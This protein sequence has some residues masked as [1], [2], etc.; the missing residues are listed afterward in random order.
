M[1]LSETHPAVYVLKPGDHQAGVDG[2]SINTAY[3]SHVTFYLMFGS[4]T[5]DAVLTVKSGESAGTKTTSET[6]YYRL[7]GGDQGAAS[8]DVLAAETSATTLTLTAATYDNR[9]L[10]IEVPVDEVTDGQPWLTLNLSDD[11]DALNVAC[12]AILGGHRYPQNQPPT[13][14]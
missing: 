9:L 12:V 6:F 10:A 1:R 3:C 14:I 13:S 8:A 2:D 11:A 5:G 7:A 4:I